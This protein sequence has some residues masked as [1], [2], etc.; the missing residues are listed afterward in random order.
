[1]NIQDL[2][3]FCSTDETRHAITK[4]F[5]R[6]DWT[7]ATDG[8]I[9]VRVPKL[10]GLSDIDYAKT[11][12]AIFSTPLTTGFME[13]DTVKVPAEKRNTCSTCGGEG[14]YPIN[15]G[16][17]VE[18]CECNNCDGEGKIDKIETIIFGTQWTSTH[19]LGL[20]ASIPGVKLACNPDQYDKLWFI[21]DGGCGV[22]MPR[23]HDENE[24]ADYVYPVNPT[25]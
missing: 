6:G 9:A 25:P 17:T 10:D 3:R 18:K 8:R 7:Y 4:P 15:I 21:F 14:S 1:M 20:V 23:Q 5:T 24:E 12:D 13:V 2:Q 11:I 22:L 16:G 19:Y